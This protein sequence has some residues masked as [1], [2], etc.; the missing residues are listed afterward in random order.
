MFS[1]AMLLIV[2]II[3]VD[4]M[5]WWKYKDK[6]KNSG[7]FMHTHDNNHTIDFQNIK[8]LN[9]EINNGKS[10]FWSSFYTFTNEIY[11]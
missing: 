6:D 4:N 1:L 10:L 7:L 3:I 11:E 8:I 5:D 9:N 2:S